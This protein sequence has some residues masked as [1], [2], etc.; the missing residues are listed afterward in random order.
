MGKPSLPHARPLGMTPQAAQGLAVRRLAPRLLRSSVER[1]LT[2][3]EAVAGDAA[4]R[5]MEPRDRAFLSTLLLTAFRHR[6]EIE[7]ILARLVD[8]PLPRKSGSA[9]EILVLG[10]AQLLFL[11]MAP[12]AVIDLAV[13]SAKADR[14]A[15]HFS[16]LV[17]AV[18]RK[19][20]SGGPALLGGLDA[21]RLNTPDW[22]WQRWVKAYGEDTARAIA[23]AHGERPGLDISFRTDAQG[24]AE[25][26]GGELLPNDQVRLPPGHAPVPELP[27]FDEGAWWIQDVAATFPAMLLGDVSGT[28]V[29]DLCAAP[30][31]KTLQ[32]AAM[33]ARVTA[34]DV[35]EARLERLRANLARTGLDAEVL[36]RDVM[37]PD[38]EG[39]WDAVLLDAPCSATGTIRRHPELPWLKDETAVKELSGMQRRML[40]KAATLVRA[41][42]TLVYCTC[43][44]EPEEGEVRVR[45]FLADHPDFEIVPAAG[46]WLPDGAARPEG[47]LRTLPSM[48][49]GQS[50]GMDGFFALAMRRRA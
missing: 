12:H 8:R 13:R 42:G 28:S 20:A 14:N 50:Q 26:L 21:P 46:D 5:A 11:G 18:L 3:E 45:G 23:A 31:G 10:V 30:G 39:S 43:S 36:A 33:G 24:W 34:V 6:G 44:L 9:P 47:W 41:G 48:G 19:V 15:L 29:L 35:S 49:Y 38:L 32:L 40:R 17:N 22:L 7:A 4:A 16:G 25:R 27:G 2:V 37:S 1:R